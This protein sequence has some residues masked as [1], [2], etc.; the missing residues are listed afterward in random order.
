MVRTEEFEH[1]LKILNAALY[2]AHATALN[3]TNKSSALDHMTKQ[4]HGSE[5]YKVDSSLSKEGKMVICCYLSNEN[6]IFE[7]L[8]RSASN[9]GMLEKDVYMNNLYD[10]CGIDNRELTK[11]IVGTEDV[12]SFDWRLWRRQSIKCQ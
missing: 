7:D 5:A 3:H 2:D 8:V 4:T 9:L 12:L 1:D 6:Q 10:E 11:P